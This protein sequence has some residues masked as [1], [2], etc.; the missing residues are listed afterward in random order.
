MN[1][2]RANLKL[3]RWRLLG[4]ELR[5]LLPIFAALPLVFL[6]TVT[7]IPA[8]GLFFNVIGPLPWE[9]AYQL[10]GIVFSVGAVGLLV[11]QEKEQRSLS[12]LTALPIPPQEIVRSKLWAGILGVGLVWV[13]CILTAFVLHAFLPV[14]LEWYPWLLSLLISL[15]IL[16]VGFAIVWRLESTLASLLLLL[17]VA[18]IPAVLAQIFD[19]LGVSTPEPHTRSDLVARAILWSIYLAM[20]TGAVY[21]LHRWGRQA[22]TATPTFAEASSRIWAPY[23]LTSKVTLRRHLM[24]STGGLTWQT[25][26]QNRWPLAAVGMIFL[27]SIGLG[28][29]DGLNEKCVGIAAV[30]A[31]LL[32]VITFG[33][34]VYRNQ[35]RFLADR[36]VSRWHVW[37]TRQLTPVSLIS[38]YVLI[39]AVGS[40]YAYGISRT[41]L[42]TI[43]QL[44]LLGMVVLLTVYSVSQWLG[45]QFHSPIL[46]AVV[47]PPVALGSVGVAMYLLDALGIHLVYL[48][49]IG[50]AAL[51][52][53]W[54]FMPAWMDR[55]LG[56]EPVLWQLAVAAMLLLTAGVV[57]CWPLFT[58]QRIDPRIA[59]EI[60]AFREQHQA[61]I[62]DD[63]PRNYYRDP[64]YEAEQQISD[65]ESTFGFTDLVPTA[66]RNLQRI[67]YNLEGTDHALS[68][69]LYQTDGQY[70]EHLAEFVVLSNLPNPDRSKLFN[71]AI[72]VQLKLVRRIR[73]SNRLYDQ[74]SADAG[75]QWLLRQVLESANTPLFYDGVYNEVVAY[76]VDDDARMVARRRALV[77]TWNEIQAHPISP[78][79]TNSSN[80]PQVW[81][82]YLLPRWHATAAREN[83]DRK[84]QF[85]DL[86]ENLWV[87]SASSPGSQDETLRKLAEIRSITETFYGVGPLGD[88]FRANDVSQTYAFYRS[89]PLLP[90]QHWRAGWE[91]QAKQLQPRVVPRADDQGSK[92]IGAVE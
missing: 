60:M 19:Y 38:L 92:M 29:R 65:A 42:S 48:S 69:T 15:Y 57:I 80:E 75:E 25:L 13:L 74:E 76:L 20:G 8:S 18:F 54:W 9:L 11:C 91:T 7:L 70:L 33:G 34:D 4:K 47:A 46:T 84:Q 41:S 22:L 77:A 67:R 78:W 56:K 26:R 52:G 32:G 89:D 63:P 83:Y 2:D 53:T 28:V 10:P 14:Q 55:R 36:G 43:G 73:L 23:R 82:L 61:T 27:A 72:H 58:P 49:V 88:Y 62:A 35:V 24:S 66:L 45:Q 90:G 12:W 50:I 87:L 64:N 85:I 37:W 44:S 59:A 51:L 86:V 31:S 16:F 6:G 1:A 71:E 81:G 3:M 21:L 5:Q 40:V 30:A 68:T 39:L 17:I 79:R